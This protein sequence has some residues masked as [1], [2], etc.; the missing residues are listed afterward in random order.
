MRLLAVLFVAACTGAPSA[1]SAPSPVPQTAPVAA[2]VAAAPVAQAT[3][4]ESITID[5]PWVRA[6]PP[7]SPNTALFGTL[8]NASTAQARLV[9]GSSPLAGTVEIHTHVE[10]EGV[11]QMRQ[12]EGLDVPGQGHLHL[13]PGGDHVMLIGLVQPVADGHTATVTLRFADDSELVVHA[14]VQVTQ[15]APHGGHDH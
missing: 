11:M 10:A 6:M 15:I 3:Q 4:A 9:A 14:P 1:P 2:P 13:A 12:V 8:N 7:G 5:A